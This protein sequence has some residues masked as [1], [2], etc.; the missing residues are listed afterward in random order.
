MNTGFKAIWVDKYGA[1][2]SV[3]HGKKDY[4]E[5]QDPYTKVPARYSE[6]EFTLPPVDQRPYL[7]AFNNENDARRFLQNE[8]TLSDGRATISTDRRVVILDSGSVELWTCEYLPVDRKLLFG[9]RDEYNSHFS[10]PGTVLCS[11]IKLGVCLS[12]L[13]DS[14][15]RYLEIPR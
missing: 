7:F 14:D 15:N 6:T 9:H 5:P 1:R 3:L 11:Q 4:F 13:Y 8:F 10:P 12:T 2:W